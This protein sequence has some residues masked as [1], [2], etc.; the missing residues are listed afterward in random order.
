MAST[1]SGANPKHQ[2]AQN[3]IYTHQYSNFIPTVASCLT[4][5]IVKWVLAFNIVSL[6]ANAHFTISAIKQL[7]K[8]CNKLGRNCNR[9]LM[10]S[11][12]CLQTIFYIALH[13]DFALPPLHA[14]A[15]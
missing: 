6:V 5:E 1:V 2:E 11:Y 15:V 7:A 3:V 4:A 9:H 12:M 13:T 10:K 8:V 14:P